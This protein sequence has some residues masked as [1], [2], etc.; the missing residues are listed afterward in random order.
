MRQ[1]L[2]EA[3]DNIGS[4]RPRVLS[5][6][7]GDGGDIVPVLADRPDGG[8]VD[9]VLVELDGDLATRAA[10]RAKAAGL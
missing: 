7:A 2:S 4:A 9:A 5:L 1:R 3:L 8:Q 6:C 10:E